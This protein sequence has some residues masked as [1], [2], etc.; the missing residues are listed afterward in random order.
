MNFNQLKGQAS[1]HVIVAII[2]EA[3]Y[4]LLLLM[5]EGPKYQFKNV[6]L[7]KDPSLGIGSYGAI[8]T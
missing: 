1:V 7:F 4:S 6:Q 2:L 8:C 5:A 3:T